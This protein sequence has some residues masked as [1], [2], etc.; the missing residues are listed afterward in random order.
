MFVFHITFVLF[1]LLYFFHSLPV[2]YFFIAYFL[3]IKLLLSSSIII[4]LCFWSCYYFCN[5][6]YFILFYNLE[7]I[8][9]FYTVF[10][11][12]FPFLAFQMQVWGSVRPK[13]RRICG[14]CDVLQQIFHKKRMSITD[15]TKETVQCLKIYWQVTN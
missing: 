7:I 15:G 12:M 14:E 6:Y 1:K 8:H 13:K 9:I 10:F 3:Y 11:C 4:V 5:Y 2:V